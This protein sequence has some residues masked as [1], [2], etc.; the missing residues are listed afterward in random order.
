[1]KLEKEVYDH[2]KKKQ[3]WD[4]AECAFLLRGINLPEWKVGGE[5]VLNLFRS[6]DFE[7]YRTI[8]ETIAG[9]CSSIKGYRKKHS[10]FEPIYFIKWARE[11]DF[12]IPDPLKIMIT[13][14]D[15][16]AKY[17]WLDDAMNGVIKDGIIP[18]YQHYKD[19]KYWKKYE[20]IA[21]LN[22]INCMV[23]FKTH[24]EITDHF[25]KECLDLAELIDNA[26]KND[27]LDIFFEAL[28]FLKLADSVDLS[29][30][31]PF[32]ELINTNNLEPK[33]PL[34]IDKPPL[35]KTELQELESLRKQKENW[36]ESLKAA[37]AIGQSIGTFECKLTRVILKKFMQ[38]NFPGIE[39]QTMND[40]LWKSIP[41][42][43]KN[44]GK[45]R[46]SQPMK[47]PVD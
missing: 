6:E 4:V 44:D 29:I 36:D 26:T 39:G 25:T 34:K 28:P 32:K 35:T 31:E 27:K 41:E 19:K 15:G 46:P 12:K 38:K 24:K 37:F 33:I 23:P 16:E 40:R 20:C 5:S 7:F 42:K 17:S 45:G 47:T 3:Y 30:P 9:K 13:H 10:D 2:Y 21:L 18:P 8:Q 43:V 1:M 14:I 22:G 11:N